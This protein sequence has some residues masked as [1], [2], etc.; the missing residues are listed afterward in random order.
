MCDMCKYVNKMS[1]ERG[2]GTK[3]W[4]KTE[5]KETGARVDRGGISPRMLWLLEPTVS[6]GVEM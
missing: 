6:P 5:N 4:E 2:N 1:A 3:Q